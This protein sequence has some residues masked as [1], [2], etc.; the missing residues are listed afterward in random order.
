[1]P[2]TTY[3]AGLNGKPG[4]VAIINNP[5]YEL[6]ATQ[7]T[8]IDL[9]AAALASGDNNLAAADRCAGPQEFTRLQLLWALATAHR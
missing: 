4:R 7:A 1:M 5:R 3:V 6:S 9:C 2:I 8:Q